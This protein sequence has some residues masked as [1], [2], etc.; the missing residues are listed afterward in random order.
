MRTSAHEPPRGAAH[1]IAASWDVAVVEPV[2][3]ASR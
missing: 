1:G 2:V 3:E